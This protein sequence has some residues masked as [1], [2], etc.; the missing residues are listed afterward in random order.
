A[1]DEEIYDPEFYISRIPTDQKVIDSIAKERNYAYYQLGVIYKEKFQEYALAKNKLSLL[2]KSN[3][4]ERLV[5]PT[6]YNLYKLYG[7]LHET[8]DAEQ[9]KKDVI[10][11]NPESRY[12]DILLNPKSELSKDKNSPESIY[13][14][15]Y[16]SSEAQKFQEVIDESDKYIL[17]FEGEPIV[18]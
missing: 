8:N 5:L 15:T 10:A 9:M 7:R 16:A 6:K 17:E 14:R 18:P 4:E 11:N 3:P 12:A 2:M 13:E 1:S